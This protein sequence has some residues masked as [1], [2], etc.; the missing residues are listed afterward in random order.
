VAFFRTQA[1]LADELQREPTQRMDE[2][3]SK[4]NDAH[5]HI[6]SPM[7]RGNADKDPNVNI[8]TSDSS[9]G[10]AED[11]LKAQADRPL[12]TGGIWHADISYEPL[13]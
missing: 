1:N 3:S 9:M 10:A 4:P 7:I 13:D 6:H 2:L 5:L 12:G 8:I 11:I